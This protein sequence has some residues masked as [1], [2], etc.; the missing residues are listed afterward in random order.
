MKLQN[1]TEQEESNQQGLFSV[2][3]LISNLARNA[4]IC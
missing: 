1:E 4:G 3:G 2:E